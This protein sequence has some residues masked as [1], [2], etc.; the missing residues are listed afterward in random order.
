M[1]PPPPSRSV[2][3]GS[4][5][6]VV[7]VLWLAVSFSHLARVLAY[8]YQVEYSEGIVLGTAWHWRS[9]GDIYPAQVGFPFLVTNY[10]PLYLATVAAL[11][12]EQP[13][14]LPG[15]LLATAALLAAC[16]ALLVAGRWR[17]VGL[18]GGVLAGLLF[19]QSWHVAVVAGLHRVDSLALALEV[20]GVLLATR[21]AGGVRAG[22]VFLLC[23]AAMTKQSY[24]LGGVAVACFWLSEA[25][26]PWRRR[27]GWPVLLG[28]GWVAA[29][30]SLHLLFGPGFVQHTVRLTAMGWEW[31]KTLEGL[32]RLSRDLW[33]YLVLGAAFKLVKGEAPAAQQHPTGRAFAAYAV[34]ALAAYSGTIGKPGAWEGYALQPLAA[35]SLA[36]LPA[37]G[38]LW[39]VPLR[40]RRGALL[41]GALVV[42]L[43]PARWAAW[44]EGIPRT[45]TSR[46]LAEQRLVV[47]DLRQLPGEGLAVNCGA[48]LL[49]GKGF[50]GDPF[51]VTFLAI[52][53]R[54]NLAPLIAELRSGR[55]RWVQ[56]DTVL[57]M[58]LH[59]EIQT[60]LATEFELVSQRPYAHCNR[61]GESLLWVRR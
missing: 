12:G 13:S 2:S 7:G 10:P 51:N 20:W 14:F 9:G 43:L 44:R 47:A 40:S 60:I 16:V 35:L 41:A 55:L 57:G 21:R 50:A 8:P 54:Y 1:S 18:R 39:L 5:L 42:A 25:G 48:A 38:Q 31:G 22:G 19:W 36:A 59:P 26:A 24:L 46:D 56:A 52:D 49:A 30:G 3:V 23:L 37:V 15:R 33:P 32:L 11:Q 45:P 29:A 34:L 17:G 61:R 53:G 6:L 58:I 4:L 27:L 28:A